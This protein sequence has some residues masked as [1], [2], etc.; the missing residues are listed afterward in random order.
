MQVILVKPVRKLGKV[1]NTVTVADGFGRNY[2]IPQEFAIRATKENIAKFASL[3]KG[4]EAKNSEHKE[5]AE[6]VALAIK[7]KH[8]AFIAQSA[9]D[10]RLFGSVSAKAIALELSKL[11][12]VGLN[13][14]NILLDT[15]IKFN[16]VFDVQ[17]ILHPEVITT[18]LVVVAKTDTEAQDALREYKEGGK[19]EAQQKEDEL[20]VMEADSLKQ[21]AVERLGITPS[22]FFE[23]ENERY[24]ED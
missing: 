17:V 2:L 15:P 12:H 18:I 10:G 20:S 5:Q 16:G 7:G 14:A 21:Q 4:M 6:K 3:Q 11:A 19:K 22:L 9:A 1:G 24:Y 23:C 13:Y 8:I